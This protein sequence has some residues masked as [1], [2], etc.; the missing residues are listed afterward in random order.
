M[1]VLIDINQK[2][3]I[4]GE[5]RNALKRGSTSPS[6]KLEPIFLVDAPS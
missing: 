5:A 3:I 2:R 4:A 1:S 6:L